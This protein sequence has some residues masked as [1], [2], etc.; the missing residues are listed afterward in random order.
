MPTCPKCQ[1]DIEQDFGVVTCHQCGEILMVEL[2]GEVR[3]SSGGGEPAPVAEMDTVPSNSVEASQGF[4]DEAQDFVEDS[5]HFADEPQDFTDESEDFNE[6]PSNSV[7]ALQ[8]VSEAPPEDLVP[9]AAPS[10]AVSGPFNLTE[11]ANSEDSS[12]REGFLRVD[13]TLSGID[14]KEIRWALRDAMTDKKFVWN[15]DDHLA[16][17]HSGV[18]R[19]ENISALK[20]SL[21]VQRLRFLPIEITWEQH[22]IHNAE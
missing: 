3:V 14:T 10:P 16:N 1:A 5:S 17:L 18:M 19:L 2:D 15:V 9:E 6:V 11:F 21:L 4:T 12:A 13:L 8:D 22:A 20:A 7:E